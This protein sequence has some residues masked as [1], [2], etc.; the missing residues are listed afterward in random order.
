LKKVGFVTVFQ[1]TVSIAD[2]ARPQFDGSL[3]TLEEGDE[4]VFTKLDRGSSIQSLCIN[5]LH[6][7]QAKGINV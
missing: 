2:K 4:I 3:G 5:T 6:D 7:L 1:E